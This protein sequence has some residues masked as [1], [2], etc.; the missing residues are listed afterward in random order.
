M[1]IPDLLHASFQVLTELEE[2][3]P[4][5]KMDEYKASLD[6]LQRESKEKQQIIDEGLE[7]INIMKSKIKVQYDDYQQLAY[8]LHAVFIHQGQANYGHYWIYIYDHKNT[9][10]WKYND[11]LV[12]KVFIELDI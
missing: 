3:V 4:P 7:N 1:S 9:Q 5:E 6:L 10:W 8:R 12:T 11:S 2:T